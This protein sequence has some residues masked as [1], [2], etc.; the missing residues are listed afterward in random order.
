MYA[1][2]LEALT[3]HVGSSGLSRPRGDHRRA[4]RRESVG[5]TP[6]RL[7]QGANLTKDVRRG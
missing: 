1:G 6:S 7:R 3:A 2:D 5:G 4:R